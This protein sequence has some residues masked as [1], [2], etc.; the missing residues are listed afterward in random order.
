VSAI[1]LLAVC[2]AFLLFGILPPAMA[3][4]SSR[5]SAA[6]AAIERYL[7]A[8][9]QH[10]HG[11]AISWIS[12]KLAMTKELVYVAWLTTITIYSKSGKSLGVIAVPYGGNF[13][14]G[15]AVDAQQN[16]YV[17]GISPQ[18]QWVIY[19]Y[20]RGGTQPKRTLLLGTGGSDFSQGVA[21]AKDGTVYAAQPYDGRTAVFAPGSI[22][23]TRYLANIPA[24]NGFPFSLTVDSAGTLLVLLGGSSAAPAI[25]EYP[26]GRGP[27][28]IGP[29]QISAFG[30]FGIAADAGNHIVVSAGAGDPTLAVFLRNDP[31][32]IEMAS[33]VDAGFLAFNRNSDRLY[34]AT[35]LDQGPAG[36]IAYP[37]LRDIGTI[38][39]TD[40]AGIAVSPAVN[41]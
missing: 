36:V 2:A 6:K 5:P 9:R 30:G 40:N 26:N 15:V 24:D 8:V 27:G 37:S 29:Y 7:A 16:V 17:G 14:N 28:Y 11:T 33:S 19:E 23:P 12:P 22:N 35:V 38:Q 25:M 18:N 10:R 41:V 1:R 31:A 20:A 13:G 39:T 32:P 3:Q 4:S 21:V 34:Y